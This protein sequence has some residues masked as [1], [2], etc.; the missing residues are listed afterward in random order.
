MPNIDANTIVSTAMADIGEINVAK[1]ALATN[2]AGQVATLQDAADSYRKIG[3]DSALQATVAGTG[4]LITEQANVRAGLQLGADPGDLMGLQA[5]DANDLLQAQSDRSV[6][7]D[8]VNKKKAISIFDDPLGWIQA[9]LSINDDIGAFNAANEKAQLAEQ[10][11][12]ERNA[13][14]DAQYQNNLR[15]QTTVS[16]A[17]VSASANQAKQLANIQ[18]DQATQQ[19]YMANAAGIKERLNLSAQQLTDYN[20]AWD[21]K[22]KQ[23]QLADAQTRL[24]M[25]QAEFDMQKER[26]ARQK[27]QD[28]KDDQADQSITNTINRGLKVMG[29][30][31]IDPASNG[32]LL[33][34]IQ[35]KMPLSDL[36]KQ[37]YTAGQ[38]NE[39]VDPTGDRF[40]AIGASPA[41]AIR[42]LQYV[43]PKGMT[44][45]MKA[46]SNL[47]IGTASEIAKTPEYQALAGKPAEQDAMINNAVRATLKQQEALMEGPNNVYTLPDARTLV[48]NN[49]KL[50]DLPFVKTVLAPIMATNAVMNTPS[51]VYAAGL[52]AVRDGKIGMNQFAVDMSTL[53]RSAQRDNIES[54]QLPNMGLAPIEAYNVK[55]DTGD[56]LSP[57]VNVAKAGDILRE[58]SKTLV[59]QVVNTGLKFPGGVIERNPADYTSIGNVPPTRK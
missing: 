40:K 32:D 36:Y 55:L 21:A 29:R 25:S 49:P 10:N 13:A 5:K 33:R 24:A 59:G 54:K 30:A 8:T 1:A 41:S 47:L 37:A 35:G 20:L 4:K 58:A 2:T 14:F 51:D 11:I 42:V 9:R 19:A 16:A 57:T 43:D 22:V 23:Q 26:F 48:K 15:Q 12:S 18:A 38:L 17:S 46:G 34:Q 27:A 50:L 7:L 44:P 56:F 39:S 3:D 52:A 45:D 28:L 53:Y 31:P 6:A